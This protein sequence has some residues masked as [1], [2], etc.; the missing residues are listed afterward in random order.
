MTTNGLQGRAVSEPERTLGRWKVSFA[1][2]EQASRLEVRI[3]GEQF[4]TSFSIRL[5]GAC[6]RSTG[7]D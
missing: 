1:L 4:P 7:M 6:W 5:A 3:E 2:V